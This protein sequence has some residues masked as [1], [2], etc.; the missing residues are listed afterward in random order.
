LAAVGVHGGCLD[1]YFQEIDE[2]IP[3][4]VKTLSTY[5]GT[6]VIQTCI[7]TFSNNQRQG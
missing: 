6:G 2:D 5:A 7:I 1:H 3:M 4:I